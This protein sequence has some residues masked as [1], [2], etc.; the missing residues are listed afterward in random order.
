MPLVGWEVGNKTYSLEEAIQIATEE[1]HFNRFP[2]AALRT[3]EKGQQERP[4]FSFSPSQASGCIRQRILKAEHPYRLNPDGVWKMSRGTAIHGYLDEEIPGTS[5]RTLKM[6][7]YFILDDGSEVEILMTGTCDYYEPS[8]LTLFDYKT[9]GTFFTNGPDGKRVAKVYPTPEHELQVNLYCSMLRAIGEPVERAFLWYV[10]ASDGRKVVSVD[11]WSQEECL[12]V[13]YNLA[14]HVVVAKQA[15]EKDGTLPAPLPP[16]SFYCK[17][18]PVSA[19][20]RELE[21]KGK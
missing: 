13:A 10:S 5:E 2:V 4:T 17:Y 11:L 16:D 20:C 8:T 9:T 1:G 3:M 14:S 21:K 12:D 6:P 18:C 19:I 15:W 7:L